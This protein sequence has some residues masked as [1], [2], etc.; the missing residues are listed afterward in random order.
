VMIAILNGQKI[1]LAV[2]L[3]V[4]LDVLVV[5]KS[6]RSINELQRQM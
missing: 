4:S 5:G 3:S 1:C 6:T 2:G